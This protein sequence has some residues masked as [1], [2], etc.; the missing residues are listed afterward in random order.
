MSKKYF[1]FDLETTGLP[2]RTKSTRNGYYPAEE[3][4]NFD[5]SRIVSIGWMVFN[6]EGKLLTTNHKIVKPDNF[7][8]SPA[9]LR[10]HGITN[11]YANQVGIPIQQIL[12]DVEEDLIKCDYMIA[13]NAQFDFNILLS[14]CYRYHFKGLINRMKNVKLKCAQKEVVRSGL[15]VNAKR[16]F[17]PRLEESYRGL[18]NDMSFNTSHDA[19][20]DTL[21]CA[22]VYFKV[23]NIDIINNT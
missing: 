11:E 20:D 1:F 13:Y 18:F 22:Q 5:S 6:E 14:E 9:A 23:N 4:N 19:L 15:N 10:V 3:I 16:K 12:I 8:S 17:Y 21:R 7:V 2:K